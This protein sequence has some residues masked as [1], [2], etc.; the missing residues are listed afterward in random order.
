MMED[1][2]VALNECTR[3]IRS[4]LGVMVTRRVHLNV[5]WGSLVIIL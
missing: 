4:R 5:K 1:Q 2:A 3:I